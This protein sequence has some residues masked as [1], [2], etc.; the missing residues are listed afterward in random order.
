MQ[1][2]LIFYLTMNEVGTWKHFIIFFIQLKNLRELNKHHIIEPIL[3]IK[4]LWMTIS[5]I[6]KKD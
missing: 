4:M 5:E 3:E 1:M 2:H 6:N